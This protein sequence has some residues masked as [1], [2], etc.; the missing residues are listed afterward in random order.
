MTEAT[1][2]PDWRAF[3]NLYD[4]KISYRF[5]IKDQEDILLPNLNAAPGHDRIRGPYK[6]HLFYS[7]APLYAT[8]RRL[9]AIV[10]GLYVVNGEDQSWGHRVDVWNT[11]P[12]DQVPEWVMTLVEAHRPK[13]W[14]DE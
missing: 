11:L 14:W 7:M 6:L 10:E 4:T 13:E 12:R 1:Q 8:P 3:A 5:T 2:E 9:E